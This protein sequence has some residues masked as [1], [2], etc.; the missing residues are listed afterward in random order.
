MVSVRAIRMAPVASARS[1]WSAWM[2]AVCLVT[3][4]VTNGL[5][6]RSPPTHDPNRRN[7]GT[8]GWRR[9]AS[10]SEMTDSTER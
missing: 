4:A 8:A 2:A 1:A 9:P 7:A 6:S 10:P 3:S 5:P